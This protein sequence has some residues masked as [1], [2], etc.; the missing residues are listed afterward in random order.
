MG[1]RQIRQR[2][3][4][5]L[6]PLVR[7]VSTRRTEMEEAHWRL[8]RDGVGILTLNGVRLDALLDRWGSALHV[9]DLRRLDENAAEFQAV[10]AGAQAGCETYYSYKTNPVPAVLSRLHGLGIGAEVI[11]EYELWLALRLGVPPER[12]VFNGPGRSPESLELAVERGVLIHLNNRE[13]VELVAQLAH[14]LGRRAR[15]GIRVGTSASWNAQ[16]GE[17]IATGAALACFREALRSADL[18]VIALHCHQGVELSTEAQARAMVTELIDFLGTLRLE[19]GLQPQ[20]LDL[21]GGLA[22]R[23]VSNLDPRGAALNRMF[24]ADLLPRP[25]EQVLTIKQYT[26]QLVG[27]VEAACRTANVARPRIFVEPGRAMTGNTQLLLCRV[28]NLKASVNG[29]PAHAVLDAGVNVAEPLKNR[30]HQLFPVAA[31]PQRSPTEYRLVGPICTPMDVLC[32]CW[33]LPELR[34]GDA[35]AIMDSGAYFVPFST[36]FSFPQPAIIALEGADETL[37]RRRETFEDL[38]RRDVPEAHL[39]LGLTG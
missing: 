10:P 34:R 20:I 28:M 27:L 23:T 11:S 8:K 31:N 7:A 22:S 32:P 33:R 6:R 37:L 2:V 30:Y 24:G 26:A 29:E 12:I 39:G 9:V 15:V 36:S 19:L 38:I 4:V 14:K 16:F 35:L 25:P 18:E 13:E 5:A 17:E 3:R 1:I 21:G